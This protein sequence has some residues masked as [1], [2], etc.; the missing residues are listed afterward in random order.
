[1]N[2]VWGPLEDA[3]TEVLTADADI[4]TEFSDAAE[5]IRDSWDE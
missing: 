2:Q 4:A 3:M 1:M 5:S